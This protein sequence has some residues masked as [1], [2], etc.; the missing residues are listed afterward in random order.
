MTVSEFSNLIHSKKT[1]KSVLFAKLKKDC[2]FNQIEKIIVKFYNNPILRTYLSGNPF[3]RNLS[4][5]RDFPT[6]NFVNSIEGEIAWSAFSVV[7]FAD[8][9]NDFVKLKGEYDKSILSSDYQ[10]A[11]SIVENIGM[12]YGYSFWLIES[13]FLLNEQISTENNWTLLKQ[14]LS[15]DLNQF[16]S[17]LIENI[18]KRSEKNMSS[19]QYSSSFFSLLNDSNGNQ[20][21]TIFVEYL[22]FRLNYFNYIGY[23]NYAYILQLESASPLIDRYLLLRDVLCHLACLDTADHGNILS[24]TLDLFERYGLKDPA[25]DGIKYTQTGVRS[26]IKSESPQFLSIIEEYTVGDYMSAIKSCN[27]LS[28]AFPSILE[29]YEMY[30]K[31]VLEDIATKD[32]NVEYHT[33]TLLNQI[34]TGIFCAMARNEYYQQAIEGL[35]K[36]CLAY[37]STD[38]AK[39]LYCILSKYANYNISQRFISKYMTIYSSIDNPNSI[40]IF[41]DNAELLENSY[42]NEKE[43]FGDSVALKINYGICIGDFD[44]ISSIDNNINYRRNLYMAKAYYVSGHYDACSKLLATYKLNE[45][46]RFTN[47]EINILLFMSFYKSG[48]FCEALNHYV[49]LYLNKQLDSINRNIDLQAFIGDISK[50]YYSNINCYI[51]L[52]IFL[53][54]VNSDSYDIYVAYDNY[55]RRFNVIKPS[56]LFNSTDLNFD[57]KVIFFFKEICTTEIMRYSCIFDTSQDVQGERIAILKALIGIDRDNEGEYIEEITKLSQ[58]LSVQ[59]AIREVNKGR[60]TVN[61]QELIKTE[62]HRFKDDILRLVELERFTKRNKLLINE[63]T[64]ILKNFGQTLTSKGISTQTLDAAF[65]A[66]KNMFLDLRDKFLFSKEYG[67][68]G[69]LSTRIRHGTLFNHIRKVFEN[70]NLVSLKDASQGY[71]ENTYWLER[72]G[73]LDFKCQARLSELLSKF[74]ENIDRYTEKIVKVFMQIQTDNRARDSEAYFDYRFSNTDIFSLYVV[75]IRINILEYDRFVEFVFQYLL[76]HTEK[77]LN[78]IKSSLDMEIKPQFLEFLQNLSNET[79]VENSRAMITDLSTSIAKCSTEIQ[80]ELMTISEWFE[81]SSP[82]TNYYVD[83]KTAIETSIEIC[84]G[85]HPTYVLTPEVSI[86]FES[87]YDIKT[88]LNLIYIIKIL[89]ENIVAHS[90][91]LPENQQTKIRCEIDSLNLLKLT[92]SNLLSENVDQMSLN[93]KLN[94]VK[95]R[96]KS[97]PSEVDKINTE[98][99][100]GFD[101]IRKILLIDMQNK[102]FDFDFCVTEKHLSLSIYFTLNMLYNE[103][104]IN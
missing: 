27:N 97:G 49:N 103:N 8:V 76:L 93:T 86:D 39:T 78:R 59:N 62:S 15:H 18:S 22:C 68:D 24:S 19:S 65:V 87:S 104:P 75:S 71:L 60:I 85:I 20:A 34:R 29:V 33:D 46:S 88:D 99:G 73:H 101:K 66:F 91:L 25:L 36:I 14:Y 80:H 100:S 51:D 23:S 31:I 30:S 96:W 12:K 37:C 81:F 90:G 45:V 4:S 64:H 53:K 13:M 58:S 10:N 102:N 7:R 82:S 35:E 83:L 42:L 1:D 98:G 38:W 11:N 21:S 32:I 74:S 17:Y 79:R 72:S 52:T 77:I 63:G 2:S 44:L 55:L 70:N 50:N 3:P 57:K 5:I 16:A 47:E 43:L 92:I 48:L 94:E 26:D 6:P 28:E 67:L 9:I 54:S 84:N 41:S 61:V 95:E 89:L 56:E 69:Y 40:S